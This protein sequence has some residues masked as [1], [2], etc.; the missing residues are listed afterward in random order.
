MFIHVRNKA[1]FFAVLSGLWLG[2]AAVGDLITVVT[3]LEAGDEYRL[4]FVTSTPHQ[5][6]SSVI[7]TRLWTG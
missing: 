2:N 5:A 3:N 7:T 1:A 6:T 4:V